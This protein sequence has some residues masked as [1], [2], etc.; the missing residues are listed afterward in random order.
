MPHW[1]A[2]LGEH[3]NLRFKP[4]RRAGCYATGGSLTSPPKPW[5]PMRARQVVISWQNRAA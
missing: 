3:W 5:L 2:P 1:N 4:G